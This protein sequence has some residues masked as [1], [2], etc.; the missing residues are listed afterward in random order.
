METVTDEDVE[1]A[2]AQSQANEDKKEEHSSDIDLLMGMDNSSD[3]DNLSLEELLS[4]ENDLSAS[5]DPHSAFHFSDSEDEDEHGDAKNATKTVAASAEELEMLAA[6]LDDDPEAVI[7][8]NTPKVE[9]TEDDEDLSNFA[10]A[11]DSRAQGNNAK[12][13]LIPVAALVTILGLAG[14]GAWY[15]LSHGKSAG[16]SS[17]D[18]DNIGTGGADIDLNNVAAVDK[19][20]DIKIP[21]QTAAKPA[22]PQTQKADDKTVPPASV[23]AAQPASTENNTEAAAPEPLTIQKIKKDFSQP[24]TYLSVSKIVWDVPEYLTYNDDFNTYLQTLGSTLKLNLSSDLLLISENTVFNKVRVKIELKDSGKKYSAELAE[25]C[26]TQV[27]D[28]LV[29]QSVKNTLNLL[30][31]PVNSLETAD[32]ELFITIYL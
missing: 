8:D 2:I 3:A 16:T 12:K 18:V 17:I 30:K 14:A 21:A 1:N 27:V 20:P 32:E 5:D 26:G 13:M 22:A 19:T 23:P 24:N 11:V 4:M 10:F 31:P 29:L 6:D 9:D 25:G 15:Y 28:D 7:Q